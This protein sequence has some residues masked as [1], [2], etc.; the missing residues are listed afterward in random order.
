MNLTIR[1][2]REEEFFDT[3]FLTREAF[4]D[5]FKPGCDEHLV[6]H[7]LRKSGC[8]IPGL[9]LVALLG[10]EIIGHILT[11]RARVVDNNENEKTILCLGPV[12]V[13][14][15]FQ[16]MGA[17]TR[18]INFTI[19]EAERLGFPGIILYGNPD[20]YHRFGFR[21]AQEYGITTRDQKNFE[22]FMVLELR[23]NGLADFSGRFFE[24]EAFY[25]GEKELISFDMQFPFREKKEDQ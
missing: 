20:Y 25:V 9:D 11:T 22:P 23:D 10:K 18:L 19:A 5:V 21:N 6:L 17:G 12:S 15:G 7:N 14:P 2:T 13:L 1:Q 16:K 24:D 4:W 8:Y 3:E